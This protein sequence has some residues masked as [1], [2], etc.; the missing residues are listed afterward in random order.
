MA[1][2]AMSTLSLLLTTLVS[3]SSAVPYSGPS[4]PVHFSNSTP[5][6]S[7]KDEYNAKNFFQEFDFFTVC[8]LERENQEA[9]N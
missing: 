2:Q 8:C 5:Q 7:L 9:R 6:Y 4:D 3:L 1:P